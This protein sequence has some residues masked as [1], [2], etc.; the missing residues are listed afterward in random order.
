MTITGSYKKG[1]WD[2]IDKYGENLKK[3][4]EVFFQKLIVPNGTSAFLHHL[5]PEVFFAGQP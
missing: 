5:K 3:L 2:S 4:V 1:V